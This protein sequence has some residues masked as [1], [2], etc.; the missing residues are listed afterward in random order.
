[1]T[2]L[3]F[4]CFIT[5]FAIC[6]FNTEVIFA[7]DETEDAVYFEDGA[8][9]RGKIL[10]LNTTRVIIETKGGQKINRSFKEIRTIS[11]KKVKQKFL[12]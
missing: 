12:L 7:Q 1:M 6:F 11:E 10:E 4:S 5:V 9:V 3:I 8:V 2:K